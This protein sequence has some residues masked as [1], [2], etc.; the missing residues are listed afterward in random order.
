MSHPKLMKN[1]SI[2][3]VQRRNRTSRPPHLESNRVLWRPHPM[4]ITT[5]DLV[6]IVAEACWAREATANEFGGEH[7]SQIHTLPAFW[8]VFCPQRPSTQRADAD[9]LGC[10][11]L[12]A[13]VIG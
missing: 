11:K 5:H 4:V 13:R 9:R 1:S 7:M 8:V 3:P 10:F 6:L 2:S 12:K